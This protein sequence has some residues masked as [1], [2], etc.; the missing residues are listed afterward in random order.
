MPNFSDGEF[1]IDKAYATNL[2]NKRAAFARVTRTRKTLF[3]TLVTTYGIREN[4]PA[5]ALGV[6]GITMDAL[7]RPF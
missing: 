2:R 4:D 7:F 5:R 3:L 6:N 1:V